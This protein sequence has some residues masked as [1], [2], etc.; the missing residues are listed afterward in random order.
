MEEYNEIDIMKE[1][2]IKI[3]EIIMKFDG[4]TYKTLLSN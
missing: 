3:N 2:N 4:D 1:G